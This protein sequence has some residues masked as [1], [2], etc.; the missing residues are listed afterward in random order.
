MSSCAIRHQQPPIWRQQAAFSEG[1][2]CQPFVLAG[3]LADLQYCRVTGPVADAF[4][5]CN[6]SGSCNAALPGAHNLLIG[7]PICASFEAPVLICSPPGWRPQASRDPGSPDSRGLVEGHWQGQLDSGAHRQ[8]ST[9]RWAG[10]MPRV[11][12]QSL[13][14]C[15]GTCLHCPALL[16][17]NWQR[18][19]GEVCVLVQCAQHTS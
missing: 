6:S 17:A 16:E 5:Y 19:E 7:A 4:I 13:R 18:T 9:P 3:V 10:W 12:L 15:M 2:L 1:L 14:S 8:H 11:V